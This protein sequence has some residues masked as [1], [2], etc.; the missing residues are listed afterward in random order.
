MLGSR[1][2]AHLGPQP[3]KHWHLHPRLYPPSGGLASG[4]SHWL[5][6][7]T[8]DIPEDGLEALAYAI[9]SDWTR[10]GVK[11]RHDDYI[12]QRDA[13]ATTAKPVVTEN[14]NF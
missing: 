8:Q 5:P 14:F 13:A 9:R 1:Q 4:H 6:W 3:R 2:R 10:A 11:K 12:A 7:G